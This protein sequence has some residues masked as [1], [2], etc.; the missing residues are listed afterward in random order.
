MKL[1][2]VALLL[3]AACTRSLD[4]S[5]FPDS[6]GET[7]DSGD[8]DDTSEPVDTQD[9]SDPASF[10]CADD[11]QALRALVSGAEP[12]SAQVEALLQQV[13][14]SCGWPLQS[15]AGSYLFACDCGQGSWQVAGDFSGWTG[16]AMQRHG[17]LHWAELEISS[18]TDAG[19]KLHDGDQAWEHDPWARRY[20]YDHNGQ[21]SLLRADRAHLQRWPGFDA[22]ALR[23]RTVRVWV[24]AS[25]G[26]DRILYAQDGQ[27]LFDP[28]AIWGGWQ[29]QHS[30]PDGVLVAAIDNSADR[31]EEYTHVQDLLHGSWYGGWGD[32]YAA[33]VHEQLRPWVSATYGDA[34]VQGLLGSSLGGLISLHIAQRYPG[35]YR[36]AASLSGTL[37]WGSLGAE[38]ETLIERHAAAGHADTAIYLDSGGS[39]TCYDSDGDGIMDDDPSSSD[40]YCETLQL[41]DVLAELGYSYEQDLWHYWEPGA[42]HNELA[43]AARVELPLAVFAGLD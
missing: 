1:V 24:P 4:D 34:D 36:F 33:F 9:S 15:E 26:F 19:Y 13:A 35:Q 41:R 30:L 25:G 2:F 22:G 38:N 37:G 21:L 3:A 23:A 27:N 43:W 8:N 32:D 5:A 18:P 42:S 16:Q 10:D 39:G 28:E 6:R 17:S 14:S 40:N 11:E 31:M 29:L 7:A 12:S 20:L